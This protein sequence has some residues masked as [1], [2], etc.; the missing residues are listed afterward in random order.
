MPKSFNASFGDMPYE[1]KLA[2]YNAQNPLVRSLHQLAYSNNPNFGY[3]REKYGL[4]FKPYPESFNKSDLKER[5]DLY[6]K[7]AE[8]VWDPARIGLAQR[9]RSRPEIARRA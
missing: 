1:Q 9:A 5:Q 3:M 7:L 2:H 6:W 8:V 4:P